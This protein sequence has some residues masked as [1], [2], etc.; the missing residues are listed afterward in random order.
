[1]TLPPYPV[2]A[3]TDFV[4]EEGLEP[5]RA[6]PDYEMTRTQVHEDKTISIV[7]YPLE[8]TAD[9]LTFMGYFLR[10]RPLDIPNPLAGAPVL[11]RNEGNVCSID[12]PIKGRSSDAGRDPH[13]CY[14]C[15]QR[16]IWRGKAFP[17]IMGCE[18][19]L[20]P[21]V[22]LKSSSLRSML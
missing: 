1:M 17:E 10:K 2:T 13:A 12:C 22:Q 15:D 4:N 3:V 6:L 21:L 11:E 14:S 20:H 18:V 8:G 19:I 7:R 16:P 9:S 5:V